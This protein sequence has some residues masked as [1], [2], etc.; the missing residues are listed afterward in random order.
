[1]ALPIAAL[2]TSFL[3][4][5][6]TAHTVVYHTRYTPD[7]LDEKLDAAQ[8]AKDD[9]AGAAPAEAASDPQAS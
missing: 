8:A 4:H 3:S 7:D 5:Y 9:D 1:M 6:R 2:I